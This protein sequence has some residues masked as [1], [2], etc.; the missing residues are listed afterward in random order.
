MKFGLVGPS[1]T[2][3][4]SA[5]ADEECINLFAESRSD[6][7]KSYLWT[8]GL[9]LFA[10]MAPAISATSIRATCW[11][12]SRLFAVAGTSL[13]EIY[14]DGGNGSRGTIAAD[15]SPASMAFNGIQLLI[16]SAGHA[17]CYTLS[18]DT[19][20][21]VTSQLVAVPFTVKFD[22]SYFVITF[23]NSNKAQLSNLL[24]GT[25]WPGLYVD[26]VSVFAGNINAIETNHREAW[27]FG[28]RNCQVYQ[29]TGSAEIFD[30]IPGAFLETGCV[31]PFVPCRV[32]NSLFWVSEDERGARVAWRSN[33]YTPQ[34]IS[35]YAV[36][37]DL[38]SYP[39][40]YG[41]TTYAYHAGGH[42]FWVL[43]IPGSQWSWVYDVSENL[44]HKRASW[45]PVSAKW[46]PHNSWN[47][48]YAFGMHLVGDWNS[49]NLYQLSQ[50]FLDDNGT[51]IRR[52]RR[53]PTIRDEKKWL[54]HSALTV[55][56]ETGNL[57]IVSPTDNPGYG[58]LMTQ[59][60]GG[61]SAV[62]TPIAGGTAWGGVGNVL[63]DAPGTSA[64]VTLEANPS[65]ATSSTATGASAGGGVAWSNPVNIDSN[66]S[67]AS[68]L[69][70]AGGS[71]VY[72]PNTG[73]VSNSASPTNQNPAN[74]TLILSGFPSTPATDTTVYVRVTP[75]VNASSGAGIVE[76]T[77]SKDGGKTWNYVVGWNST[78]SAVTIPITIGG[79][80]NL[81]SIQIRLIANCHCS[82]SGFANVS[83]AVPSLG[84]YAIAPGSGQPTAQTLQAAVTGLT[85]PDG[86]TIVG[87]TVSFN[88]DYVTDP[89]TFQ[90]GLNVG[91]LE[92]SFTLTTSP[93]VYTA[94]DATNLW[95]YDGWTKDTLNNL[96][97][98][99]FA[100]TT[101]TTTINVNTM[102]VTVYHV[103][104]TVMSDAIDITNFFPFA[105]PAPHSILTGLIVQSLVSASNDT[106][107]ITVQMLKA[108]V[109]VGTSQTM[110]FP[111]I[112]TLLTFGGLTSLFGA[113]W[114]AS[115][116]ADPGFGVRI[117]GT[118]NDGNTST[119]NV[120]FTTLQCL[121]QPD[122]LPYTSIGPTPMLLDGD[123]NPR[124]PQLM[125]RWSDDS[126]KT[127]SNEHIYDCGNLGEYTARIV[128][129]RLGRSRQRV[130]EISFTDPIPWTVVDGYLEA[131]Q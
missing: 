25:T 27:V 85:I 49:N 89:P 53:T 80:T 39:T 105:S 44:W 41:M 61:R 9:S 74:Q 102:V 116:V 6:G 121:I 7:Q 45:D 109:P 51:T 73:T 117:I 20:L 69:L 35:T 4:S 87:L 98:S 111:S 112:Q 23:Q 120:G 110:P 14:N 104:T 22:D 36:E 28:E 108:G 5:M 119:V 3:R 92:P 57:S 31:G 17:Y 32:D 95:G 130:Y 124:P 131:T 129:R 10:S 52:L 91:N 12:G 77:Y 72:C 113:S 71:P 47:H 8:P 79:I 21:E 33:G 58:K 46:G 37:I 99:F 48:V 2:A 24:D 125:L 1:Y 127:W 70:T 68:V 18:T 26:A 50:N 16:V 29:D 107:T 67:F 19:L 83:L 43:Y 30:P 63:I 96:V 65:Q 75:T 62:D 90:V 115:D 106:A 97:V 86:R 114:L 76:L 103:P 60:L 126:G 54:F 78:R 81:N 88:A 82:P 40:L 84:L 93:A 15:D 55:D 59:E 13:Q 100:S 38:G 66:V 128:A 123:G 42:P 101:G 122:P 11:A 34:R 94:G 56:V 64:S 118:A